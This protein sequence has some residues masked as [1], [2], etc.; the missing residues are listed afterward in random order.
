VAGEI[1]GWAPPTVGL[2]VDVLAGGSPLAVQMRRI[3]LG[4]GV[5]AIG[6]GMGFCVPYMY[7]RRICH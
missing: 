1:H 4:L 6:M 5:V 2:S 7:S 3:A